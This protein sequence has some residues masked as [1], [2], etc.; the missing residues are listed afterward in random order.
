[1]LETLD[2]MLFEK[3]YVKLT[4]GILENKTR[5]NFT[6]GQFI[7]LALAIADGVNFTHI[8]VL[9]DINNVEE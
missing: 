8:D 4:P 3:C 7:A 1:M 2:V 5:E 6:S 9:V